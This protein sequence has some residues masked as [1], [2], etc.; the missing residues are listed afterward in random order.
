MFKTNSGTKLGKE[1]NKCEGVFCGLFVTVY[2][3]L[4]Q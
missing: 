2:D 4:S 3:W 1:N